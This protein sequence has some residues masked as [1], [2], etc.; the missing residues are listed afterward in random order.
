MA[1]VIVEME[2]RKLPF[3]Y[4]DSGQHADFTRSLRKTFGI[5]EPDILLSN[6]SESIASIMMHLGG[7]LDTDLK[8]LLMRN[9]LK[10]RSSL[11][12]VSA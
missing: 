1:P 3:R 2:K 11:E 4:I 5:P 7:I 8:V 10:G 6:N 12:E 9:S